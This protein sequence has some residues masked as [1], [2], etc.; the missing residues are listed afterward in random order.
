MSFLPSDTANFCSH[1]VRSGFIPSLSVTVYNTRASESLMMGKALPSKA[2]FISLFLS[3][4]LTLSLSPL[5]FFY[6][7]TLP[8]ILSACSHSNNIALLTS[9]ILA[10]TP[11]LTSFF[12]TWWSGAVPFITAWSIS[13]FYAASVSTITVG[14]GFAIDK[15]SSSPLCQ[16]DWSTAFIFGV[17]WS[18]SWAAFSWLSPLGCLVSLR[19]IPP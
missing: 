18:S 13:L 12:T 3:A 4:L 19:Y 9:V 6:L 10:T 11:S 14:T 5:P 1:P 7:I 17:M 16:S 8:L 15:L 2:L